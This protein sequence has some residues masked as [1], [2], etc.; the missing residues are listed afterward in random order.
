MRLCRPVDVGGLGGGVKHRL[1]FAQPVVQPV[2]LM[3][4]AV[5]KRIRGT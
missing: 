5:R 4:S 1:P 3:P 2:A